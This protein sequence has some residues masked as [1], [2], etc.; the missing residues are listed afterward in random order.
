MV[1]VVQAGIPYFAADENPL[2]YHLVLRPVKVVSDD[3]GGVR[4]ASSGGLCF[5]E[6]KGQILFCVLVFFEQDQVSAKL[7]GGSIKQWVHDVTVLM[8]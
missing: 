7:R 3:E 8:H 2:E 4:I 5:R 1:N 6:N